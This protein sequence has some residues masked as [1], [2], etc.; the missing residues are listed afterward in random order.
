VPTSAGATVTD[1]WTGTAPPAAFAGSTCFPG[2]SPLVDEHAVT[3][4]VA[5]GTYDTV[6][7]QFTFNITWTPASGDASTN[8][9]ILTLIG[10]DG[11][12]IAS[13]DGGAPTETVVANNLAAGAYRV[14]VC[15]FLNTTLQ[16]YGGNLTITTTGIQAAP[17][18]IL[19]AAGKSWGT[20][21]K[22]T[23]ANGYGYEP[24]F[25]VDTYGNAFATAHKENWQLALAP[26]ANSPTYTRSMS[27]AWLSIDNG[28]TWV[29]PPGLTPASL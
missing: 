3:I 1:S 2:G 9:L 24:S 5:P 20:P 11:L 6:N 27:W 21:V 10:P 8:D 4:A 25:I 28:R 26:D 17:Q 18:N 13:S 16:P 19:P 22:V 7:A 14:V 15:G 29:D 23:P 12:E